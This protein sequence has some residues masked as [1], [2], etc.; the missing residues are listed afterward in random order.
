MAL[1][2]AAGIGL[3]QMICAQATGVISIA[4]QAAQSDTPFPKP[5]RNKIL[6]LLILKTLGH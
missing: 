5:Y 1:V 4:A 2:Q 3:G 6:V